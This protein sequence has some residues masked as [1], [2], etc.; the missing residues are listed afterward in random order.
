LIDGQTKSVSW[1][2]QFMNKVDI[3]FSPK[4][5]RRGSLSLYLKQDALHYVLACQQENIAIIGI[6]GF[7]ITQ[8]STQPSLENSI[9]LSTSR[10][11]IG[12]FDQAIK[13][14]EAKPDDLYFEIVLDEW[15]SATNP[16]PK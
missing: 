9:D 7:F 6:D 2:N 10:M 16:R 12:H 3:I 11:H 1:V 4:A 14:L 5:L 15:P 13:F 8:K